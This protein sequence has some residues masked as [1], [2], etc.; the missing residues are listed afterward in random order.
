VKVETAAT[1]WVPAVSNLGEF[2]RWAF[3]EI[4]DPWEAADLIASNI[5]DIARGNAALRER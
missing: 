5:H 1:Y 3:T 2:G 4:T